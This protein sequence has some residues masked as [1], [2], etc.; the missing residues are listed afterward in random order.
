LHED[1]L[2]LIRNYDR[3]VVLSLNRMQIALLQDNDLLESVGKDQIIAA[4]WLTILE[5]Y[6]LL[7]LL[8]RSYFSWDCFDIRKEIKL[9]AAMP[10]QTTCFALYLLERLTKL[11][12]LNWALAQLQNS[13]VIDFFQN[14]VKPI[15]AEVF[16]PET[17]TLTSSKVIIQMNSTDVNDS[18]MESSKEPDENDSDMESSEE[19]S[20]ENQKRSCLMM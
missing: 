11:G 13:S 5:Q 16:L 9:F 2:P 12:S 8:H 14:I 20:D 4:T 18:D 7:L 1:Q 19:T 15:Y 3:E 10:N 6:N 17:V